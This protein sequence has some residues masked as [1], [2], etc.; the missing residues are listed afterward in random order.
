MKKFLSTIFFVNIFLHSIISI[1]LGQGN[2][3]PYAYHVGDSYIQELLDKI[4]ERGY[5]PIWVYYNM[6]F[7]PENELISETAIE[8]QRNNIQRQH[9]IF[10]GHGRTRKFKNWLE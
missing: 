5:V 9:D 3:R 7:I 4:E 6:E 1:S 10:F 8:W 2:E